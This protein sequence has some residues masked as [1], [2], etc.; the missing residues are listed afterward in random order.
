MGAGTGFVQAF[1]FPDCCVVT[2]HTFD[3][4]P[5]NGSQSP[6]FAAYDSLQST[7]HGAVFVAPCTAS[8][9]FPPSVGFN[10]ILYVRVWVFDAT[11]QVPG[12][13]EPTQSIAHASFFVNTS[14]MLY[15][16]V[17]PANV[18]CFPFPRFAVTTLIV[19]VFFIVTGSHSDTLVENSQS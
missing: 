6:K 1:P 7:S 12:C 17:F 2:F 10:V 14:P 11:S 8:H 13:H 16:I 3:C 4:N 19:V 15:G 9:A 18:H 5:V